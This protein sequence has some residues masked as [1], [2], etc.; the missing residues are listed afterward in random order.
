MD[1]RE[2]GE[3]AEIEEVDK[4]RL[5]RHDERARVRRAQGDRGVEELHR[6]LPQRLGLRCGR[7]V[8]V[9]GRELG[10]HR[11]ASVEELLRPVDREEEARVVGGAVGKNGAAPRVAEVLA[12]DGVAIRPARVLAQME[13]V[14]AAVR[15]DLPALCDTRLKRAV[16]GA[17]IDER[18]VEHP[19]ATELVLVAHTLW[20]QRVHV[21]AVDQHEIGRRQR[22]IERDAR[23]ERQDHEDDG[24]DGSHPRRIVGQKVLRRACRARERRRPEPQVTSCRRPRCRP[25]A[26]PRPRTWP[27]RTTPT[28]AGVRARRRPDGCPRTPAAALRGR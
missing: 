15:R 20:I 17:K 18:L 2:A 22:A 11:G 23:R 19:R 5:Q 13:R 28:P 7:S 24:R 14:G 1:R 4:R 9:R 16:G 12:G 21:A 26:R 6:A 25:S 10:G 27:C 3:R 8:R